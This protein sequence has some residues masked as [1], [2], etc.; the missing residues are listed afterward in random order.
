MGPTD[1]VD[2]M[3]VEK[4]GD[5]IT[6]KHKANSSFILAPSCHALLGIRPQQIA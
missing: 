3:V 2:I 5:H 4:L 1:Q 6:P